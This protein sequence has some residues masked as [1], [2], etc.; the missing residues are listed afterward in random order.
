MEVSVT[1]DNNTQLTLFVSCPDFS[2]SVGGSSA[3]AVSLPAAEG[4]CRATVSEP[5]PGT[6]TVAYDITIG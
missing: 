5:A 6:T 3:M 1:W 4:S 2:Q